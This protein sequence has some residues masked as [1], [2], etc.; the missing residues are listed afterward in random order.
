M[1][2]LFD[3]TMRVVQFGLLK[4]QAIK[5]MQSN[6]PKTEKRERLKPIREELK[7]LRH[8]KNN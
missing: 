4:S 5:I 7:K 2:E 6:I 1:N 8:E 3:I